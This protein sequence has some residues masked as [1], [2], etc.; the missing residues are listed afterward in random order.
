MA[1]KPR[2]SGW[3]SSLRKGFQ[4][5]E[6]EEPQE[7]AAQAQALAD[8]KSP[9]PPTPKANST[10]EPVQSY[11]S[12]TGGGFAG[13]EVEN[14]TARLVHEESESLRTAPGLDLVPL[15]EAS[16]ARE[17]GRPRTTIERFPKTVYLTAPAER[18]LRRTVEVM[19]EWRGRRRGVLKVQESE[20][21]NLA[22][23]YLY[24]R[25]SEGQEAAEA[26]YQENKVRE[27]QSSNR[28]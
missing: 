4:L 27:E 19:Q 21:S 5:T 16:P 7:E 8:E 15:T 24:R 6:D 12:P 28:I 17:R 20:A 11:T 18:A 1:T 9:G 3:S 13:S 25:L 26:F 10:P 23:E 14:R 22:L 2:N